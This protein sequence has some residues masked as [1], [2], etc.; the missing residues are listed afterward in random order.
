MPATLTL[1]V[2]DRG[3]FQSLSRFE[4]LLQTAER[5]SLRLASIS[6]TLA[7]HYTSAGNA[8][9]A[10]NRLL[11][12]ATRES[13][14]QAQIA[15]TSATHYLNS[16][17]AVQEV[18]KRTVQL[19]A[20]TIRTA[21]AAKTISDQYDRASSAAGRFSRTL[22]QVK[23]Q[24][25]AIVRTARSGAGAGSTLIPTSATVT[26]ISKPGGAASSLIGSAASFGKGIL[27]G[28]VSVG[29]GITKSIFGF[30]KDGVV[31]AF[32]F[33]VGVLKKGVL[34]AFAAGTAI[35]GN[36]IRLATKQEPIQ[37]GFASIV[38]SRG[39]GDQAE[40]LGRLR[41][42]AR[43]TVSDLNLMLQTNRALF[44]GAANT[45]EEIELLVE[46]GRRLGKAMGRD[47][48]EG[49][50]DLALGIGR[51]SRL[52][53]DNLGLI[54]SVE[55]A[56]E[57]YAKSVGV[58]VE[59]LSDQEKKLVFQQ[60]AFDAIRKKMADLGDEQETTG[61]K[62]GRLSAR[63]SNLS[64]ELGKRLLP[65]FNLL[66]DRLTTFLSSFDAD[67]II[68]FAKKT[69]DA[70]RNFLG[71]AL[72]FVLGKDVTSSAKGLFAS[73]K[74]A[75]TE[76]SESAFKVVGIHATG[77]KDTMLSLFREL[78]DKV[79]V[80]GKQAIDVLGAYAIGKLAGGPLGQLLGI[81]AGK[82]TFEATKQ[83]RQE[84]RDAIGSREE[85][86]RKAIAV[87]VDIKIAEEK[88]RELQILKQRNSELG[89]ALGSTPIASVYRQV[90][91]AGE[92]YKKTLQAGIKEFKAQQEDAILIKA[93]KQFLAETGETLN[94]GRSSKKFSAAS[95][96]ERLNAATSAREADQAKAKELA[97]LEKE[98][99]RTAKELLKAESDRAS[100]LRGV[101]SDEI[102]ARE[103]SISSL[104]EVTAV[105]L[106]ARDGLD[107]P[108]EL[109]DRLRD[110]SSALLEFPSALRQVADEIVETQREIREI[111]RNAAR[112][113]Q[114]AEKEYSDQLRRSARSFL[115]EDPQDGES[116]RVR[117]VKR[118][119]QR[120][121]RRER[122]RLINGAFESR[123]FGDDRLV[124]GFGVQNIERG[125]FQQVAGL[126]GSINT[127]NA[128]FPELEQAISQLRALD[129]TTIATEHAQRILDI[130][131]NAIELKREGNAKL[132]ELQAKQEELGQQKKEVDAEQ[133][134]LLQ[135]A[136][137]QVAR[138][139]AEVLK[140]KDELKRVGRLAR[141]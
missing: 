50:E 19:Q 110:A 134:R 116:V 100:A 90:V 127:L 39:L 126:T 42:A 107:A 89:S 13:L 81:V 61:D 69:G 66:T 124:R 84:E 22:E 98:R 20:D 95:S 58:T 36:S 73:I 77:L 41:E 93:E 133:N 132:A 96:A 32:N 112:E 64:A 65:T 4:T 21:G 7:G 91:I 136:L 92:V 6:K 125:G 129:G 82:A 47:A 138:E 114:A 74:D 99:T 33:G 3:A 118:R 57:K 48:R 80:Y 87:E 137:E 140:L 68:N 72:D 123:G 119:A 85:F 101:I 38:D 5:T 2:E 108:R 139:R 67:D 76:P 83:A 120:D 86:R 78:F 115:Q 105:G 29:A 117:A 25:E 102:R 59:A 122:N 23:K 106:R 103:G 31:G 51:Q 17:A 109:A 44:L 10:S 34:A 56:N 11:A 37:Q 111:E 12:T 18:T 128:I 135:Q 121:A 43:G 130:E 49:F 131:Q 55:D 62:L 70:I 71:G 60:A 24:T 16:A 75:I 63:F 27:S 28:V 9:Q 88:E 52:I 1:R 35:L 8:I 40:V 45:T 54:V 30:V 79:G 26:P 14:K 46:A 141:N 113:R 94:F 104:A 97:D 53:L 15:K